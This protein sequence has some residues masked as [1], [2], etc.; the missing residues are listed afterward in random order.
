[1]R[2]VLSL[3]FPFKLLRFFDRR[4]SLFTDPTGRRDSLFTDPSGRRD[5]LV[6]S[7][8]GFLGQYRKQNIDD[9]KNYDSSMKILINQYDE[10]SIW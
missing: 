8:E 6:L 2:F 9:T 10:K 3:A 7:G 4:D 5:S 1:M